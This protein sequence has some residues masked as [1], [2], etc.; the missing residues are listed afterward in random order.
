MS[1]RGRFR[2][3]FGPNVFENGSVSTICTRCHQPRPIR[4]AY[5]AIS[6]RI[7]FQQSHRQPIPSQQNRIRI[8][9]LPSQSL[10]EMLEC[11]LA[12]HSCVAEPPSIRLYA[13]GQRILLALLERRCFDDLPVAVSDGFAPSKK[14]D[15]SRFFGIAVKVLP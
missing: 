6:F 8:R 4:Y 12:D 7:I 14:F 3:A 5:L 2:C 15:S 1:S 9:F 10:P 11:T 13:S